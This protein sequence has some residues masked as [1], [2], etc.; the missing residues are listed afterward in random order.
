MVALHLILSSIRTQ[1]LVSGIPELLSSVSILSKYYIHP[2]S[3]PKYPLLSTTY[4]S[5]PSRPAWPEGRGKHINRSHPS[6]FQ[7]SVDLGPIQ[8]HGRGTATTTTAMS[9][10]EQNMSDRNRDTSD[11]WKH[12]QRVSPLQ[13][14]SSCEERRTNWQTLFVCLFV[15]LFALLL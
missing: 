13:A 8:T 1:A 9:L 14:L 3:H 10:Q 11:C 2:I 15:F 12:M 5:Y 6:E 4:S 7:F